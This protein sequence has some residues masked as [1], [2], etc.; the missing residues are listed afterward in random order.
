MKSKSALPRRIDAAICPQRRDQNLRRRSA[1]IARAALWPGAPVTPPPGCAPDA[2]VIE[3]RQR[4]A[5]VGI[6]EHRAGPRTAD[7]ATARRGRCRRRSRPNT[8]LEIE[9]AQRLAADDAGLEAGRIAVDGVDHQ[10]G[11]G[12][13]AMSVPR[14]AVGQ[15]RRHVLAEQARHMRPARRQRVVERRRDDQLDDRLAAPAVVGGRR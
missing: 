11:D 6:A 14:P 15:L 5:I 2:A 10:V 12:V 4:P 13:L 7:R 1:R 9:R 3:A 8:L